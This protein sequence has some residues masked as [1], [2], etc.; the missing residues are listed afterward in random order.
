MRVA[1]AIVIAI[2]LPYYAA[3]NP[4]PYPYP[5]PHPWPAKSPGYGKPFKAAS[6]NI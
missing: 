3:L 4:H 1:N 2:A 6:A 5:H